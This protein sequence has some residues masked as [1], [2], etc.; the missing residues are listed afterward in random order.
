M[1]AFAKEY[2]IDATPYLGDMSFQLHA[3]L[4]EYLAKTEYGISDID[5]LN[6]IRYHTVGHLG[7][8]FLEKC[9]FLADY[10]E[11]SR[12][13]PAV[14]TLA[15]MRQM[16]FSDV[17]KTL[18]YVMKNKLAYIKSCGTRLDTTTEQ[19]FEECRVKLEQKGELIS[20]VN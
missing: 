19:V 15:Q 16:A 14:P 6:A 2:E 18:Y 1:L 13:F 4:G 11:P 12:D 17:D 5:I 3:V 10:L 20:E 9:I 7:M 8:S